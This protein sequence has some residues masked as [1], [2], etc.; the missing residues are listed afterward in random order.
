MDV[1]N[2]ASTITHALDEEGVVR[3]A[4][5]SRR[6]RAAA[7]L[8]AL[9]MIVLAA[10][11]FGCGRDQPLWLDE[12]WTIAIAGQRSWSDFY[13]QVYWD[14]NAPLYYLL[15]HG[16]QAAF[17]LSDLSLRTPS[18]ICAFATPLT[19]AL[20]RIEGLSAWERLAWASVTALWFPALSFAQ[21]VRCYALLLLF[22]TLQCLAYV[23][24]I[25]APDIRRAMLWSVLAALSILTHYDAI[26][27]AAMQ[28]LL[29]L[30]IHRLRAVRTWPAA[31]W[32]LP[33]FGWL[34]WHMPRIAEFARPEIAW[35]SV[36][37]PAN[38]WDVLG[39]L[40]GR[41]QSLWALAVVALGALSLRYLWP[42]RWS[43]DVGAPF[44]P[45]R[46]ALW[47]PVAAAVAAA[48]TLTVI[49]FFRPSFAY[50]Y[51]TPDAPGVLLGL[52][53]ATAWLAGRGRLPALCEL[54]VALGGVTVWRTLAHESMAPHV[55]NYEIASQALER[56]HPRRLVFLWDHPADPIEH[57]EQLAAAGGAFFHRDGDPIPVDPVVMKAGEDPNARLLA[58]AAPSGSAI[59]WVYDL[60]V[61]GTA[62]V[63]HRP[64]IS[65]IDPSWAC[66]NFGRGRF[67]VYAC[68]RDRG[69][70]R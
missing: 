40:A 58:E 27:C 63:A 13:H 45:E 57:P 61:R 69:D 68:V 66:R 39:F 15:M 70:G 49:G 37:R 10:L 36:L 38:I 48:V 55:Y 42:R 6:P 2:R 28:G 50:R 29:Y 67:G 21:E 26:L 22:S 33:S 1:L 65:A 23:R 44:R 11:V 54:V 56:S 59:L 5:A 53:L 25:Q 41:W 14:V 31:L 35:Y 16:W 46:L 19:I 17:G 3:K 32:F 34:G 12:A 64:A 18:L 20:C 24:L 4:Q 30:A 62:A 9:A 43:M 60:V 8:F 7:A 51:L 52:A 47:S